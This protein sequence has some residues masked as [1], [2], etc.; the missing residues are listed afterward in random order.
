MRRSTIL[1]KMTADHLE[2]TA[3]VYVRPTAGQVQPRSETD[4]AS[5][6][7][8]AEDLDREWNDPKVTEVAV[9]RK[10][11]DVFAFNREVRSG[12]Q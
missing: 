5:L 6:L 11:R 10:G 4:R 3:L 2:R 7:R 1:A 8:L 9:E 12:R